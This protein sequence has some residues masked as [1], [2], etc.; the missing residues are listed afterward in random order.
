MERDFSVI[1]VEDWLR[2]PLQLVDSDAARANKRVL[3]AHLQAEWSNDLDATM[4]TMH[5]DEP[6]QIVYGLGIEVRGYEQVREYYAARFNIWSGPGMEY[7]TRATIADTCAYLECSKLMWLPDNATE[8]KELDVPTV[9][10]VDFRDGLLLGETVYLDSAH[11][12]Q[13]LSGSAG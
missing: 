4:R 8:G 11:I 10:V 13:Q 3:D 1:T 2:G 9:L 5:R 7:F 6:W 12:R